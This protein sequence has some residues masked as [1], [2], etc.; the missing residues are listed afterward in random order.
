MWERQAR[1]LLDEAVA[2]TLAERT[3]WVRQF[4]R[5]GRDDPRAGNL[6]VEAAVDLRRRVAV[7]AEAVGP[8]EGV[9][10]FE[11]VR[12]PAGHLLEAFVG[13]R[14]AV[15]AGG[16]RYVV[17]D[18]EWAHVAGSIEAPRRPADP[19]WLLDA[20]RYAVGC[21]VE[22]GE[23]VCRLDLSG[24]DDVDCSEIVPPSRWFG[25]ARRRNEDWLARVPCAVA[26]DRDGAI[27]RMS[28]AA[29]PPNEAAELVWATTEFVEYRV[30]VEIP[31]LT[32]RAPVAV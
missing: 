15:Y 6:R 4:V 22:G 32:A 27:A 29:R 9:S 17:A 21:A 13:R 5:A 18:G 20:L 7:V 23:I 28:F 16:S 26:V 8:P 19:V 30:P 10:G 31:D 12:R 14:T 3:A 2:R 24:A 1:R 25:L 11:A